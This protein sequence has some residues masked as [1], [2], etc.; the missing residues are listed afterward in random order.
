MFETILN[1]PGLQHLAEN[2][3]FNLDVE[4][5]QLFGLLNQSS[6]QI[7]E[8]RMFQDPMFWLQKFEG[9]SIDNQNDWSNVIQSANNSFK[10]KFAIISYLRWNLKKEALV[11]LPGYTNT[12]VQDD[13]RKKIREILQK[14]ELPEE[15]VN[16]LKM[17]APLT[18]N[19]QADFRW[20]INDICYKEESCDKDSEIVKIFAPLTDNPNAPNNTGETPIY[21]AAR[22]GHTE[23]VKIL[24]PLTF[25]VLSNKD[26]IFRF[27]AGIALFVLS[28]FHPIRRIAIQ[29]LV[30]PIFS[31]MVILT[32]LA[33]CY[34]MNHDPTRF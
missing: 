29:V 25:I 18:E 2:I 23:V 16:T 33:N 1:N 17:L 14:C 6:R 19:V 3:F 22:N 20:K 8:G 24:A 30:D 32:I 7:L 27:F 9:I 28:P 34:V 13:F 4:H 10:R 12:T 26:S 11:D 31:L 15:D 21:W 5:L